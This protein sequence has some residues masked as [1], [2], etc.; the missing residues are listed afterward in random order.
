MFGERGKERM[1]EIVDFSIDTDSL[2][3]RWSGLRE[4]VHG[5]YEIAGRL[6]QIRHFLEIG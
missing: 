2:Q 1:R 5:N 3:G 6:S 4:I